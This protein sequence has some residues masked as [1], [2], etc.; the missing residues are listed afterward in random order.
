MFAVL[1]YVKLHQ[2][3][4]N[5]SLSNKKSMSTMLIY[6]ESSVDKLLIEPLAQ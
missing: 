1:D 6:G 4:Y 2:E 5:V 3:Y